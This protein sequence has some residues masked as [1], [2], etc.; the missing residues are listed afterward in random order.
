MQVLTKLFVL[1]CFDAGAA[2]ANMTERTVDINP[3]RAKRSNT[4]DWW[5][6]CNF[7]ASRHPWFD[8]PIVTAEMQALA[9]AINDGG[10]ELINELER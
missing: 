2:E 4:I 1:A 7:R 8:R 9:D 10:Q 5:S 3:R 6:E